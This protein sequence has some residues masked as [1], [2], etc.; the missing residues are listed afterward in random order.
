MRAGRPFWS[1]RSHQ[2]K[3]GGQ[4]PPL[5]SVHSLATATPNPHIFFSLVALT[6]FHL[7]PHIHLHPS[8]PCSEL[9]SVGTLRGSWSSSFSWVWPMAS[10]TGEERRQGARGVGIFDL[11][12]SRRVTKDWLIPQ[13]KVT[14]LVGWPYPHSSVPQVL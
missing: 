13:P 9:A 4:P 11:L 8:P 10:S 1:C 12:P 6:V 7:P 3:R 5:E 2:V 14:A